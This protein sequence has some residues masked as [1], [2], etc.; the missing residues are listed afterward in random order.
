MSNDIYTLDAEIRT[1]LGTSASRRLRK[2]NKV[3][4][5][6]YGTEKE[7]VSLA[8]EHK[9]V[10]KSQESEGFYTHILTLNI[11][12][13]SVQAI[14]KDM[15]RHPF[16]PTVTHLD[17]QRVDADHKLHT[18][19]PIHFIGED[20]ASKS[21]ST[22]I[23]QVNEVEITCLPKDLPEFI[24]VNVA[25]MEPGTSLHLSDITLPEGVSSV[26]L[27]RDHD[28]SVVTLVAAKKSASDEES[29]EE[30]EA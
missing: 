13:E 7:A 22:V 4:A 20:I 3:P 11:G 18:N 27:V 25:E 26:E 10:M 1:D 5:I 15:Q 19:L 21:G 29:E 17:F 16:K 24:E 2:A 9:H 28:L 14:L 6:L 23:H 30:A 12:G 8:L